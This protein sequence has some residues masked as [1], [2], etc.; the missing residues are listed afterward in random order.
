M[1]GVT[2]KGVKED[3]VSHRSLNRKGSGLKPESYVANIYR[4]G[5][6]IFCPVGCQA[7]VKFLPWAICTVPVSGNLSILLLLREMS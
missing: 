1:V 7:M 5:S 4:N 6:L 3:A 2:E